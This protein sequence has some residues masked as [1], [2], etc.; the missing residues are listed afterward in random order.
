MWK[1]TSLHR[2]YVSADNRNAFCTRGAW[3]VCIIYSRWR[4]S[5]CVDGWLLRYRQNR[6]KAVCPADVCVCVCD[7][8]ALLRA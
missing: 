1:L 8:L 6:Q 3:T 2:V 4:R 5:H 7:S